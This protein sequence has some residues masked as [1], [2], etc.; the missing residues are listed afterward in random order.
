MNT[1]TAT[2]AFIDV[3]EELKRENYRRQFHDSV[4]SILCD[5]LNDHKLWS[6]VCCGT[7]QEYI[8]STYGE[9][10]YELYLEVDEL[11]KG[12]GSFKMPSWGTYGT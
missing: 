4:L 9:Q 11:S 12:E 7:G 3:L 5:K 1:V 2:K 10:A 6:E 8:T